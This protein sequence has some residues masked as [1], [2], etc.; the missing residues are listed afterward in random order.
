MSLAVPRRAFELAVVEFID[1]NGGGPGV[2]LGAPGE[3]GA[4]PAGTV[5]APRTP[6]SQPICDD[7]GI[8]RGG[9]RVPIT[10]A[11]DRDNKLIY[12]CSGLPPMEQL[13]Q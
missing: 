1:E 13:R 5:Q 6:C 7:Y 9:Q 2:R 4:I 10:S 12:G 3:A 8:V 11:S